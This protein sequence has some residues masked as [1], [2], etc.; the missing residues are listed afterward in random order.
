MNVSSAVFVSF[1]DDLVDEFDDA[2]FL[3]ALGDFFVRWK[4]EIERLVFLLHPLESFCADS[5]IFFKCLLNFRLGRQRKLDG[6]AG[7]KSNRVEH[8]GIERIADSNLKRA[9][10]DECRKNGIL[11]SDF[12]GDA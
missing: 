1:P 2:R 5:V 7:V 4:F 12:G 8:R 3:I 9:I 11:K 10:T 6:A